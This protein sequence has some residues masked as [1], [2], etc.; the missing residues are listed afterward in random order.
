[1]ITFFKNLLWD[2]TAFFR[3]GRFC[4]YI[5]GQ[6]M[7]IGVIPT[8]VSGGGKIGVMISGLALLISGNTKV[9]GK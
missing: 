1:M 8:G 6:G 9:N 5:L 2:E 4:L 3:Y 7:V